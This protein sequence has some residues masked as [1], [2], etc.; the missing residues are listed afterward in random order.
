MFIRENAQRKQK[1]LYI[2]L[3]D[4]TTVVWCSAKLRFY[5]NRKEIFN[6]FNSVSW[7]KLKIRYVKSWYIEVIYKSDVANLG[8]YSVMTK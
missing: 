8:Y 2:A 5:Q 4:N 7:V 6:E 1:K 3:R